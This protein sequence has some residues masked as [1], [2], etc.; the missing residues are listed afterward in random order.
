MRNEVFDELAKEIEKHNHIPAHISVFEKE[1]NVLSKMIIKQ[2]KLEDD[3]VKKSHYVF[4][5]CGSE[6]QHFYQYCS[7]SNFGKT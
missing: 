4:I 2:K 3:A 7:N 5:T 6:Q 1:I